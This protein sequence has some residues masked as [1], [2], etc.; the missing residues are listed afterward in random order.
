MI[1]CIIADCGGTNLRNVDRLTLI[2]DT[3]AF[4][5]LEVGREYTVT[6]KL[7]DRAANKPI[8][9]DGKEV[10]AQTTFV[11]ETTDGT[12]D[13]TFTFDGTGLE[14]TVIV[15]FETL[16]TEKKEVAVTG[17]PFTRIFAPV[18]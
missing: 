8:L 17:F 5:S 10:T 16:Y 11:P 6:G 7:M 4:T 18:L 9:V 2:I 12:V 15:V 14:D 1:V 3:V 13:V